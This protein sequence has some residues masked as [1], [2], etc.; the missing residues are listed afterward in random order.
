MGFNDTET[1]ALVGGGHAFGKCHGACMEPPCGEGNLTGI[2]PNTFT[3]GFEGQWSTTPTTWSNEYFK[4]LFKFDW[5]QTQSPAGQVQW[6]PNTAN[7]TVPNIFMLTADLA[8]AEDELYRPISQQY[9]SD[10]ALLEKDFG[11]AWYRLVSG[12]MGPATR[13][14]GEFVRPPQHWQ[15]TLPEASS[16]VVDYVAVRSTIQELLDADDANYNA[17]VNLAYQCYSTFRMTDYRGG[18]NGA[19]I[20]F[21]PESEWEANA[22]TADALSTLQSVKDA[23]PDVSFSDIIVLAG[24]TAVEGA[25]G[26][27]Q[28][29]CAGRVDATDGHGSEGL[30][31][32]MYE[33]PLVSVIDDMQVKGLTPEETIALMGRP[34]GS[35]FSNQ[36]FKDML[37]YVEGASNSTTNST[38]ESAALTTFTDYEL[39]VLQDAEFLAI[40][41]RYA[42]F[43][44]VFQEEFAKAWKK[45]MTVDR[46]DGPFANACK[47]VSTCTTSP[48]FSSSGEEE[49]PPVLETESS[50]GAADASVHMA[51]VST[52]AAV[53]IIAS[54][55]WFS[56]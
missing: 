29:F 15:H 26:N 52:A 18:C 53:T 49:E 41:N 25:G 5:V 33:P 54:S 28:P 51:M 47:S 2:G 35:S 38:T 1:V 30:E 22:G 50:G 6:T 42:E 20:R 13:C 44:E 43:E 31:P 3:A 19:R 27:P 40:V 24:Q 37:P 21:S 14:I 4:N 17:F 36:Y 48:C 56:M 34:T 10:K 45:I 39:A 23:F 46:Y 32:R 12:D 16:S 8:M 55:S 7:G 9:A 11:A